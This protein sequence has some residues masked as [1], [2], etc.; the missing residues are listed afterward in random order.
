MCIEGKTGIRV[1]RF[2]FSA[3]VDKGYPAET[4]GKSF[5]QIPLDP[6][7]PRSDTDIG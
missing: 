5:T 6:K 1:S 4:L 7:L 3:N 2:R